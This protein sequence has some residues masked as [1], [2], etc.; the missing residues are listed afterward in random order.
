MADLSLLESRL[1][2]T[3]RNRDLLVRALTHKSWAYEQTPGVREW[4]DNEQLE[5]LG[6]S[7]LGF[8]TSEVLIGRYP[9][10]TE[11]RLSKLKSH[12]VS[13]AHLHGVAAFLTV[14][15]YLL[16]GRGEELSG[17][18]EKKALLGDA[19]EALIAAV[20]LD[21]G[22][23]PAR[24]LVEEFVI[25][26]PEECESLALVQTSDAKTTLKELA[27]AKKLPAPKYSVIHEDGPGHAKVFTVEARLGRDYMGRGQ[28]TSK[29]S[30]EQAAATVILTQLDAGE[31]EV[32]P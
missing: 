9:K 31:S 10:L 19:L 22:L 17:G 12:L 26:T 32:T 14:G 29:K 5:F 28:G 25:G 18:R 16:L 27:Q 21:G 1:G 23:E 15:P 13:A 2:Y 11:G 4:V 7:V 20:Y 3:F 30:A 24:R 6:D 8:L